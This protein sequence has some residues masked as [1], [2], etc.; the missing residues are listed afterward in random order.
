M[1]RSTEVAQN[2]TFDEQKFADKSQYQYNKQTTSWK[3]LCTIFIHSLKRIRKLTRS[4]SDTSQ[5]VNKNRTRALSMKLSLSPM[6]FP[7]L[8]RPIANLAEIS[9]G[10]VVRVDRTLRSDRAGCNGLLIATKFYKW[11]LILATLVHV[12]RLM[13]Q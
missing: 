13:I 10:K 12:V 9:S 3:V 1:F 6:I 4:F 8:P 5:L 7:S 11:C 2:L